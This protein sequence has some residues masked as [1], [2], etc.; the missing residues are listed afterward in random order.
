MQF[1]KLNLRKMLSIGPKIS[2]DNR[3][4][5]FEIFNEQ[6]FC[7]NV[8]MKVK[9]VQ[10][11]YSKSIRRLLRSLHYR[12]TLKAQGKLDRLTE[13]EIFDVTVDTRPQSPTFGKCA[14]ATLSFENKKQ[15]LIPE[16]STNGF[17]TLSDTA[18]VLYKAT[19]YHAPDLERCIRWGDQA[20]DI[21]QP[22][23]KN[24]LSRNQ[25]VISIKDKLSADQ[26][27]LEN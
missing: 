3:S 6:E 23:Q 14:L 5:F 11:N 12:L 9:F 26:I 19:N 13:G 21:K 15:L 25:L 8:D 1:N 20:P 24:K 4:S 18:Q 17:L 22:L 10:D 27:S 16:R 7:D 2:K